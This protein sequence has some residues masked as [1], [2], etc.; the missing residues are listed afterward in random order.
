M[1]KK[2]T[3]VKAAEVAKTAAK[4]A[5]KAARAAKP[6]GKKMYVGPTIP[7]FATNNV[8]YDG[9]PDFTKDYLAKTPEL[10]N[11]FVEVVDYSKANRMIRERQGYIYSA[12]LKALEIKNTKRR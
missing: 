2:K 5:E 9:I 3:E 11:L 6:E 10:S 4:D 1:S 12:Y 7:G 8:V